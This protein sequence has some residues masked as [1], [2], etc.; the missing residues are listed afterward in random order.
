MRNRAAKA[1]PDGLS[2]AGWWVRVDL[3]GVEEGQEVQGGLAAREGLEGGVDASGFGDWEKIC[4]LADP[5][6]ITPECPLS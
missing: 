1:S 3:K 2:G 5:P 6:S 4:V